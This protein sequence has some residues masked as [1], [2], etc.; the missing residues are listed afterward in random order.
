MAALAAARLRPVVIAKPRT[1]LPDLE[2]EVWREPDEPRHPLRG[3]VEA[4]RRIDREAAVVC[5][6]DM[7]FVTAELFDWL[8]RHPEPLAVAATA[9]GAEP[10]LGRYARGLVEPLADALAAGRSMR[11]TVAALGARL[12]GE[13]ELR[14]FG[15]PALLVASVN[16]RADLDLAELLLAR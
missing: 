9:D 5:A 3:I 12:V 16:T 15:E 2:A 6:C 1:P 10:L 11:A 7:P 8:A 14:R 13:D 4:L